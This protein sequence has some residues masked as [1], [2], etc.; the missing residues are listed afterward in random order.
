[1]QRWRQRVGGFPLVLVLGLVMSLFIMACSDDNDDDDFE[2]IA[3]GDLAGFA[4]TFPDPRAF[5]VANQQL[6]LE[7]GEFGV[8]GFQEDRA[9]FTITTAAGV[10]TGFMEVDEEGDILDEDFIEDIDVVSEC[11]LRVEISTVPELPAGTTVRF[12]PCE[13]DDNTGEL[14]VENEEGIVSVS[15]PR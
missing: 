13:I 11:D 8:G 7:V 15:L 9:P 1:M 6:I 12:G 2:A 10:A 5:G 14:R 3:R 4:F